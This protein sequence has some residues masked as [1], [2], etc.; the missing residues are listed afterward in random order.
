LTKSCAFIR[1]F[2]GRSP[3][4]IKSIF[5]KVIVKS[6]VL[7]ALDRIAEAHLSSQAAIRR[8]WSVRKL[9]EL[10]SANKIYPFSM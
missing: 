7:L 9:S 4:K 8:A 2:Q 5:A 6:T 3:R 10:I 1:R